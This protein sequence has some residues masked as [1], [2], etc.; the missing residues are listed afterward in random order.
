VVQRCVTSGVCATLLQAAAEGSDDAAE[1]AERSATV[2]A[3]GS[4]RKLGRP[5]GSSDDD[6]RALAAEC[7]PGSAAEAAVAAAAGGAAPAATPEGARRT[8]S[9]IK[10]SMLQLPW[11]PWTAFQC[12]FLS[13]CSYMSTL[14]ISLA[15]V[16]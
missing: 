6:G 16:I 13:N 5:R 12:L 7:G 8:A 10:R 4:P 14:V 9:P 1:D 15:L 2:A 3:A 11:P